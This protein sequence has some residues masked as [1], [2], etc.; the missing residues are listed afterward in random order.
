MVC[1][2]IPGTQVLG[3]VEP[4]SV[5]AD[6]SLD[7]PAWDADNYTCDNGGCTYHGCNTDAECEAMY[8]GRV[9]RRNGTGNGDCWETCTTAADCP[10]SGASFDEDNFTC[11][12]GLCTYIGCHNDA[13]CENPAI[14]FVCR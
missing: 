10:L 5:P 7:V 3:C 6:C 2:S 12:G 8:P 1:R 4:C 9:C 14:A 11:T 13:E